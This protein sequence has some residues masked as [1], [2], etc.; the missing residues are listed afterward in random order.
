MNLNRT[1]ILFLVVILAACTASKPPLYRYEF[2]AFGTV[3]ELTVYG[4]DATTAERAYDQLVNDFNYMHNT[5]HAWR[6]GTLVHTNR[7]LAAGKPFRADD[8]IRQLVEASKALSAESGGLFN[9]AIGKLV[10][11]WGFHSD[12]LPSTPPDKVAIDAL[13][14]QRPRM[15][16][17]SVDHG[18]L[19]TDNSAVQ[20]DFGGIAKGY[21]IDR[22]I[23][24]LRALGIDNAIVNAGGDLRAIGRRGARPW[25]IGIRHPRAHG[26]VASVEIEG[27]D[28]IF[29][30]GD[31]E[32]YYIF[33]GK[34]YHHILDPRTGYPT[35]GVMSV[36]VLHKVAAVADAAATALF[37]AGPETWQ[38]IARNMNIAYGM[39][40]DSQG[41]IDLTPDM[42]Q[43]LDFT[44]DPSAGIQ[45]SAE[46]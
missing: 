30:S 10:A 2:F 5:W 4:V 38:E 15:E 28:S 21:G 34:R 27:N 23:D 42:A 29:T 31:Y 7:L 37:V 32:R 46:Q 45:L 36:T 14:K 26:V 18:T 35:D 9:P 16:D 6:E 12:A 39:L 11:L 41:Q 20:L 22:A 1:A 33:D 43:R 44:I 3:I 25:R 24:Q 19:Q 8:S 17:I 40:I 13:L